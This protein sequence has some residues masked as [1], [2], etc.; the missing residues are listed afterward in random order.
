METTVEG[1]FFEL[2]D[3]TVSHG[4]LLL[5]SPRN[6]EFSRNTDIT[7]GGVKYS[8]LPVNLGRVRFEEPTELD[9]QHIRRR[10]AEEYELPTRVFVLCSGEMRYFVVAAYCKVSENEMEITESSLQRKFTPNLT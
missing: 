4:Q 8:E 3:Y 6:S 1:R 10:F 9:H 5:R 7:F 2:W